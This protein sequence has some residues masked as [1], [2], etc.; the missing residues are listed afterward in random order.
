M[1]TAGHD[2]DGAQSVLAA[3][4]DGRSLLLAGFSGAGALACDTA[5]RIAAD[6]GSAPRVVLAVRLQMSGSGPAMRLGHSRPPPD[7]LP[8]RSF[9]F[10]TSCATFAGQT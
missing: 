3:L 1:L 2:V 10:R 4:G 5:G 8:E 6:G 7:R 9:P